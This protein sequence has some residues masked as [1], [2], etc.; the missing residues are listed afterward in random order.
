MCTTTADYQL[1]GG[2]CRLVLQA[3]PDYEALL[4]RESPLKYL[5]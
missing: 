5:V 3:P 1:A 2:A 4:G